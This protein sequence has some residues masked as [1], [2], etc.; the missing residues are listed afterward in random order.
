MSFTLFKAE[1]L[2]RLLPPHS[3]PVKQAITLATAYNNLVLRKFEILTGAGTAVNSA[4]KVPALQAGLQLIFTLNREVGF[5]RINFFDMLNPFLMA[6]WAGMTY[7]GPLGTA[8]VLF[9]GILLGPVIPETTSFFAWL[10][11]LCGA[12]AA[13]MLT[14]AGIYINSL[15]GIPLPWSGVFLIPCPVI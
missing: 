15:T 13:H 8:T 14:L 4:P 5:T 7:V 6:F 2:G 9:P 12:L 10:N 3:S 11:I 1:L